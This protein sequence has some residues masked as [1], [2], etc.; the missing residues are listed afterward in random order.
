MVVGT[1]CASGAMLANQWVGNYYVGSNGAWVKDKQPEHTHEWVPQTSSINHP[2]ESH[3]ELVK[4]A[5]SEEVHHDA[6]YKKVVDK[7]AWTETIDHPEEGHYEVE[8]DG[9]WTLKVSHPKTGKNI[10][11]N[12]FSWSLI[13]KSAMKMVWM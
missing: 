1:T 8:E 13:Q 6:E 9:Y 10:L 3:Q 12:G 5:W 7:E 2:E 11:V 4:E